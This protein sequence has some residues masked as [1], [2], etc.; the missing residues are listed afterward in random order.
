MPPPT[1][2]ATAPEPGREGGRR[3]GRIIAQGSAPSIPAGPVP[4]APG[5]SGTRTERATAELANKIPSLLGSTPWPTN[6][7]PRCAASVRR[8]QRA[9]GIRA[10]GTYLCARN[11]VT[12]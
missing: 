3:I 2:P 12:L 4:I 10:G 9:F 7:E 1:R 5:R 11:E 6:R 8:H